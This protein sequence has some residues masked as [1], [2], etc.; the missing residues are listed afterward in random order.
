MGTERDRLKIIPAVTV[1]NADFSSFEAKY[2]VIMRET[3]IGIPEDVTV[4]S[5][6]KRV[7]AIWYIPSP[8]E[9]IDLER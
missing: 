8:S 3:V 4:R 2:L 6:P 1:A 9:P 5:N 7:R